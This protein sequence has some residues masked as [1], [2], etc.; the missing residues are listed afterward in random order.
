LV[1]ALVATG[2]ADSKSAA[3]RALDQKGVYVNNRQQADDRPLASEDT[4]HGRFVVLR[5]GKREQ[6]LVQLTG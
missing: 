6:A 1:D 4:L 2:L 3:R 5:R